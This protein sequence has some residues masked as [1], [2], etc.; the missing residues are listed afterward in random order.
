M[1]VTL[2]AALAVL[3]PAWA[4]VPADPE[5]D[6]LAKG[7]LGVW[8]NGNGDGVVLTSVMPNTAASRAGLQPGDVLVKADNVPLRS[9]DDVREVIGTRRPGTV[10]VIE[11]LRAGKTIRAKVKLGAKP[12][13]NLTPPPIDD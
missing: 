12:P 7:F 5:P 4:P 6:P 8:F 2:L 10:V 3:T 1:A 13:E 11:V 9:Q